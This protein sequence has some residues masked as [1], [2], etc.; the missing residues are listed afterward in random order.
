MS[1]SPIKSCTLLI[2]LFFH[3]YAGYSQNTPANTNNP[4]VTPVPKPIAYTNTFINYIRTWEPSM[5]STDPAVVTATGRTVAEVKQ[6]TQFIDGLGRPLQ[7]LKNGTSPAGKDWVV[8]VTYDAFGREKYS[9]QPYVS[10]GGMG[11]LK[12]TPLQSRRIL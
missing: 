8:P 5:P 9:Y 6:T 10:P 3:T 11:N 4:V 2:I 12:P 1:L 7:T